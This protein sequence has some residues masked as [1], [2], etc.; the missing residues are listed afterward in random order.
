MSRG[1]YQTST[2]AN[3]YNFIT[4][5][6]LSDL[7]QISSIQ[8]TTYSHMHDAEETK[9]FSPINPCVEY[10]ANLRQGHEKTKLTLKTA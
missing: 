2:A 1:L 4:P 10:E 8:Q 9:I 3:K 6:V 5:M 7:H